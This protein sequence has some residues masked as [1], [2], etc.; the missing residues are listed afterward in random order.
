[1]KLNQ[2]TN[3]TLKKWRLVY[4]WKLAFW[5]STLGKRETKTSHSI[6]EKYNKSGGK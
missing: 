6:T 2:H 4:S 1:M 5:T 3:K